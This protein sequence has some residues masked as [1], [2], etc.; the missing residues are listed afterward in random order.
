MKTTTAAALLLALLTLTACSTPS[1]TTTAP[2]ATPQPE[3]KRETC[4][5]NLALQ[6]VGAKNH[7]KPADAGRV[8]VKH[9]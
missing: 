5:R 8:C 6:A 2:D 7:D 1:A 3:A 9:S 4:Q